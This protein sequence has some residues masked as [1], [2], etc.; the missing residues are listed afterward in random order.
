M[1]K[2]PGYHGANDALRRAASRAQLLA[3]PVEFG[4]IVSFA[5]KLEGSDEEIVVATTR[6]ETMLGDTAVAVHPAD[7]RYAHLHGRCVTHPFVEGR[8]IPIITDGGLVDMSFGEFLLTCAARALACAHASQ[9]AG[10]GAVKITP[11]HDPNDFASGKRHGLQFISVFGE[12][13]LINA[14]GGEFAG[15]PRFDART[16]VLAALD[17]KARPPS[18]VVVPASHSSSGPAARQG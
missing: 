18:L 11:A 9:R 17:K 16:A 12:D 7:P 15:L 4:V 8:R 2:V 1:V 13:G 14:A 5:Y 6:P 10:T 3:E